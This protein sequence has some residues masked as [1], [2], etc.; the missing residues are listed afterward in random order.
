MTTFPKLWFKKKFYS[1]L[2][3]SHSLNVLLLWLW[4]Y[5]NTRSRWCYWPR[6]H[7]FP[8]L[9][10]CSFI[11]DGYDT[12]YHYTDLTSAS[13]I[14]LSK[15][16]LPSQDI[17]NDAVMGEGAYLTKL[18]PSFSR[19]DVAKNNYDHNLWES[20]LQDGK[21]DVSFEM[22]LPKILDCSCQLDRD[23]HLHPGI[24]NLSQVKGIKV[25][26]FT[27]DMTYKTMVPV[28]FLFVH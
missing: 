22:K 21:V 5:C 25:H 8:L 7:T 1:K 10:Y 16:I 13:R 23:V 2:K 14:L 27:S 4:R 6:I 20:K 17:L 26:F 11:L 24:I 18:D 28:H 9:L 3:F 15:M 12:Y 19:P